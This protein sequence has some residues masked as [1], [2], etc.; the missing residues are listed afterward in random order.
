[1][2]AAGIKKGFKV[3]EARQGGKSCF[4]EVRPDM[5]GFSEK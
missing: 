2:R 4:I 3:E 5:K 1:M